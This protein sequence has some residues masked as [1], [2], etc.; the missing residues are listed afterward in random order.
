MTLFQRD[1][2]IVPIL[3]ILE[4]WCVGRRYLMGN[5]SITIGRSATSTLRIPDLTLS[6]R[7]ARVRWTPRGYVVHDLH[8][9]NGSFLN[10]LRV[11]CARIANGDRLQLGDTLFEIDTIPGSLVADVARESNVTVVGV[12]ASNLTLVVDPRIEL[13]A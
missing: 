2:R 10:G 9:R 8:S 6:R 5:R 4:G 7:H 3:R 1:T 12:D 11:T 13:R